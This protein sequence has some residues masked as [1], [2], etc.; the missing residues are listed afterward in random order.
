MHGRGVRLPIAVGIW[1][2]A[3]GA[4]TVALRPRSGL[5]EP[6]PARAEAYFRPAELDRIQAYVGPQRALAIG[7]LVLTGAALVVVAM[8][9][10]RALRRSYSRRRLATAATGAGLV[11]GIGVIGLPLAAV[12]HQRA[13]DYGLSTQSWGGWAGDV[14]K[15]EAIGAAFA[16]LGAVL[17]VALMRR[18]PRR[19][20]IPAG[21]AAADRA[22][23]AFRPRSGARRRRAAA[24]APGSRAH[25]RARSG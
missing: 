1:V 18:F 12:S 9:P 6:A 25:G 19:W 24:A 17:L 4:A 22:T 23:P 11:V 13:V 16:G 2:A 21:A 5:I 7:G 8:R 15:S 20:W 3:A 10:P 14:A